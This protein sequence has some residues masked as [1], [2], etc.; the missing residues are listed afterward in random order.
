[1]YSSPEFE[2]FIALKFEFTIQLYYFYMLDMVA[3][4]GYRSNTQHIL[5][6][7]RIKI[8]VDRIFENVFF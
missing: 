6:S 4:C 8:R 5:L 7:T 1:M 2:I 3:N